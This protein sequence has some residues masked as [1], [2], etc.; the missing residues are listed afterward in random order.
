[1]PD[2]T[3]ITEFQELSS[4]GM[5]NLYLKA[6]WKVIGFYTTAFP[7]APPVFHQEPNYCLGWFGDLPAP[8]PPE[9]EPMPTGY[10]PGDTS[11]SL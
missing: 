5:A 9:P 7:K 1:M 3:D 4:F 10:N 6:G 2:F 11:D 8:H